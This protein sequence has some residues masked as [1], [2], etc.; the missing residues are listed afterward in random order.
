MHIS[1]KGL[2]ITVDGPNAVGKGTFIDKLLKALKV[3]QKIYATKEPTLT[4]LGKFTKTNEG[5]L[6]GM[7]Y[8]YLIAA[9]RCFHIESEILPYLTRGYIVISDRYIESSFVYQKYDGI[10]YDEI[11]NLNKN[12]LIPNLS[13]LLLANETIISKRL[14]ERTEFSD[15]EKKM[16]R[17]DELELY[18]NAKQFLSSKGYNYLEL[19]NNSMDE[20]ETNVEITCLAIMSLLRGNTHE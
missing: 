18:I 2:F 12:F 11:W 5:E 13:I 4:R 15:Y 3:N 8:A 6:S 9:D 14:S 19:G 1:D 10:S 20:L 16:R 17:S 7:P